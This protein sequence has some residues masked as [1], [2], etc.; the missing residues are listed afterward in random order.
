MQ[1]ERA[2]LKA[3]ERTRWFRENLCL[4]RSVRSLPG[5]LSVKR[6]GSSVAEGVLVSRAQCVNY[7]FTLQ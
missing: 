7:A 4:S 1:L 2:K 3:E 6:A 5:H